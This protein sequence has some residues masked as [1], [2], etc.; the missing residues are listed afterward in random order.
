MH[1]MLMPKLATV[2]YLSAC[3]KQES[4]ATENPITRSSKQEELNVETQIRQNLVEIGSQAPI[5]IHQGFQVSVQRAEHSW[6]LSIQHFKEK[7]TLY[8]SVNDYLWLDQ[9]KSTG[10][11]VAAL[12]QIA[13]LNHAMLGTKVQLNPENSGI[14]LSR[15]IDDRD[16]TASELKTT[17]EILLSAA[18]QAHP[19]LSS[20]ISA[21]RF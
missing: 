16:V 4:N 11:T 2:V 5:E 14:T 21:S 10:N 8:F 15:T 9:S 12:T 3:T 13:T 20:A 6:L 17:T 19:V 1:P 18:E 7:N